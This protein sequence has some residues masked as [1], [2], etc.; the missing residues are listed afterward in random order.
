M[1]TGHRSRLTREGWYYV[2]FT[3]FILGGAAL[4]EVNLLV[5]MGGLMVAPIVFGW[6][7]SSLC[8]RRISVQRRLPH[9]VFA[10]TP[11][12]VT[13]DVTNGR[14][15]TTSW[16]LRIDE[17]L[18]LRKKG[19]RRSRLKGTAT[20]IVDYVNPR[21]TASATYRAQFNQRGQY[22]FGTVLISTQFPLGLVRSTKIVRVADSLLVLPRIGRLLPGWNTL[23]DSDKVGLQHSTSRQG[24][25]DG[26]YYGLRDWQSGDNRRWIH[27]RTTAR[28]GKL[29]VRQFERKNK[30][31]LAL[32]LD[33]WFGPGSDPHVV[34]RAISFAATVVVKL[35]R[36][37]VNQLAF[38]VADETAIFETSSNRKAFTDKLLERLASTQPVSDDDSL[39][40]VLEATQRNVRL[41]TKL[42]VISTRANVLTSNLDTEKK[43]N[44]DSVA[45]LVRATWIDC[46]SDQ[47]G[48][49][50]RWETDA[51][52]SI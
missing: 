2:A 28:I 48:N 52:P 11:T 41:G 35:A 13:L 34:E 6:R 27:W 31:D 14:R 26:D 29:A 33:P 20:C 3:L 50:F 15:R 32:V 18:Q 8:L 17:L 12:H 40:K 23:L 7:F 39:K 51:N 22:E 1:I 42:V 36:E 10:G 49:Y 5:V 21:A 46:S 30:P 45:T 16:V 4:R 43:G 9:R 24:H 47:W 44:W 25:V 37:S 38:G 19:V